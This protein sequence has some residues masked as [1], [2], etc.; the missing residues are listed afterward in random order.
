MV[1]CSRK[2]G[3]LFTKQEY[4]FCRKNDENTMKTRCSLVFSFREQK[5]QPN[6]KKNHT[7]KS[8]SESICGKR[9]STCF[10]TVFYLFSC[11]FLG[12]FC[13]CFRYQKDPNGFPECAT[14]VFCLLLQNVFVTCFPNFWH[15]FL[16]VFCCFLGV[17]VSVFV[18]KKTHT[19]S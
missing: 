7:L 8:S 11:C 16:V 10:Q 15:C 14:P 1:N 4:V 9:F 13:C 19:D 17:F 2:Q 6:L 3:F 18:T 12:V 5:A